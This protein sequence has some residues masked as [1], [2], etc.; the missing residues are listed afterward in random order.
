MHPRKW[1]VQVKI[2]DYKNLVSHLTLNIEIILIFSKA[3]NFFVA[4]TM[5]LHNMNFQLIVNVIYMTRKSSNYL[6]CSSA[7]NNIGKS[8][9]AQ[10]AWLAPL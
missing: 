4:I 3:F 7:H 10:R 5:F 2:S 6:G 8:R 1:V 9:V